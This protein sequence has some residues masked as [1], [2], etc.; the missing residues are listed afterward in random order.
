MSE[1]AEEHYTNIT[2]PIR[3][4]MCGKVRDISMDAESGSKKCLGCIKNGR[5]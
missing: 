4:A 2:P 5:S 3:C 1:Y